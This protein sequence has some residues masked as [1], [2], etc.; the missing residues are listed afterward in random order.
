[1]HQ[2]PRV[3]YFSSVPYILEMLASEKP[4]L[5]ML[6]KMDM[7]GVGGAALSPKIG[8]RIVQQEVKLLSRFGSAEC[9][10]LLSSHRNYAKDDAWQFL[11]VAQSSPYLNFE[12]QSD[13]SGLCELVILKGWPHMSKTN[14]GDGSFATNDLFEPHPKIQSAWRY[15]SRSDSQI[16][17]ATGKKF[18]PAPVEDAIRSALTV[19]EDVLVF[20][21]DKPEAGAIVIPSQDVKSAKDIEA[22]LWEVIHQLNEQGQSHTGLSRSM[23]AI[24]PV[25]TTTF[26]K[27]SKGSILRRKAE[28]RFAVDI[29]NLYNGGDSEDTED[30]KLLTDLDIRSVVKEVVISIVGKGSEI[31]DDSDFYQYGVDSNQCTRIRSQLQKVRN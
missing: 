4:S 7:V 15:H 9:G 3:K 24:M 8:D 22:D 17:L 10:F 6:T 23:I 20:G 25:G 21:N 1:M 18:D 19:V 28:D 30:V 12:P 5:E 13:D 11:R 31:K 27:S 14:R 2:A 16:T 29:E 26:D